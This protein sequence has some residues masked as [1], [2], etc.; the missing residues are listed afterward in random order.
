VNDNT[1]ERLV[2]VLVAIPLGFVLSILMRAV[3]NWFHIKTP[4]G[5]FLDW[6]VP[7]SGR[8]YLGG[9]ALLYELLVD[10]AFCV[11]IL[12]IFYRVVQ[13]VFYDN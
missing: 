13:K 4:G 1:R 6:Y 12:L 3:A 9:P 5:L 2:E 8:A 7:G 10:L 11:L